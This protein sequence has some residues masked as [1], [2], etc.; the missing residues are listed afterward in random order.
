MQWRND[1]EKKKEEG[2]NS[3]LVAGERKSWG[4]RRKG[5]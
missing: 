5:K 3:V 2:S 1:G 4:R